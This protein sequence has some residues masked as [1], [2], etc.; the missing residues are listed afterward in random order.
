[1]HVDL[2]LNR[3]LSKACITHSLRCLRSN[4]YGQCYG[5]YGGLTV[6][7]FCTRAKNPYGQYGQHGHAPA[8]P[9]VYTV[10]RPYRPYGQCDTGITE[11]QVNRHIF[12]IV[13]ATIW[14]FTT[15]NRN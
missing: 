11:Q 8:Q 1:M 12:T 14:K 15:G 13:K 9:T 3:M 5:L 2:M 10:T 6:R 4:P 7:N